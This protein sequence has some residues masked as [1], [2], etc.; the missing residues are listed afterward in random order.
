MPF[1]KKAP[2]LSPMIRYDENR[3]QKD[4]FLSLFGVRIVLLKGIQ[5]ILHLPDL[6]FFEYRI[7]V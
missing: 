3:G 5:K 6:L 7:N 4:L 2:H 1:R